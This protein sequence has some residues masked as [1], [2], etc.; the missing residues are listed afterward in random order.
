MSILRLAKVA[1]AFL[2]TLGLML[3]TFSDDLSA[4]S[5]KEE[6]KKYT[7]QLK[8]AKDT[9]GKIEA[10]DKLGSLGQI[11]YGYAE[12][13]I[14]DILKSAADKDAGVRAAAAHAIG[15]INIEDKE[16]VPTLVKLLKDDNEAV[17]TAA[18]EGLGYMNNKAKDAIKDLRDIRSKLDKKD[19]LARVIDTAMKS[20][21]GKTK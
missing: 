12:D 20:I 19:K 21:G 7:E 10:L 3:I 13:A 9:V 15:K 14:P 11:Q 18:V 8:K 4:A 16:A 17:K 1:S 2:L 5:K 6:A